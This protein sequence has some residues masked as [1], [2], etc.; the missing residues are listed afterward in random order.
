MVVVWRAFSLKL[1]VDNST[2]ADMEASVPYASYK[3]IGKCKGV[4]KVGGGGG[5]GGGGGDPPM[6]WGSSFL[7]IFSLF[8]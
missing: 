8:F 7:I 6:F 4:D 1:R 5:G 2:M 3:D